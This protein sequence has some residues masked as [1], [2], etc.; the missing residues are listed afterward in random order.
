M[1]LRLLLSL[2]LL[3]PTLAAADHTCDGSY[4]MGTPVKMMQ[5]LP[6]AWF[7]VGSRDVRKKATHFALKQRYGEKYLSGDDEGP[8]GSLC[9]KL[10]IGYVEVTTSDFGS[11]VQ[12]SVVV[13]K[14]ARCSTIRGMEKAFASGTGLRLGL[15]KAKASELLKTRI[16]ADLTDVTFEQTK[17][18]SAAKVLYTEVLSLAFKDDRLV[19]FS[20]Y[21]YQE[22]V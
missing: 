6:G 16:V 8:V 19:R 12:Y 9:L 2:L 20:V 4:P 7:R 5:P 11:G 21:D 1:C 22:G 3:L 17:S 18:T 14:C 10:K 15:T 13:P